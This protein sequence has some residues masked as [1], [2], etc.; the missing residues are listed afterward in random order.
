MELKLFIS[1]L[2]EF[3]IDSI[4]P[5]KT[6]GSS[7]DDA[8]LEDDCMLEA[9][10]ELDAD[11]DEDD[12]DEAGGGLLILVS[13]TFFSTTTFPSGVQVPGEMPVVTDVQ[14]RGVIQSL[15]E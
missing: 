4:I 15:G 11:M 12:L 8:L 2:N 7:L 9:E 1:E 3:I 6:P 14:M 13:T 10:E 5:L